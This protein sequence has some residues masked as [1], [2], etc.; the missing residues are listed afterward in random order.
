M[1]R[2]GSC[3]LIFYKV[4]RWRDEALLN[5]I[6]AWATRSV[7]SHV[8]LAIGE[9]CGSS[10]QMRNV[11]RVFNDNVRAIA[12]PH[13]PSFSTPRTPPHLPPPEP[14]SLRR[15]ASSSR[16][17][18]ARTRTSHT[19]TSAARVQPNERCS[20]LQSNSRA[21][22][23]RCQQWLAQLYG[24]GARGAITISVQV[25]YAHAHTQPAQTSTSDAHIPRPVVPMLAELVAA[26]LQAGGL[27]AVES[28]PGGATPESLHRMYSKSASCAGNP[29]IL[30]R[31]GADRNTRCDTSTASK[32]QYAPTTLR[33]HAPSSTLGYVAGAR[34]FRPT[35]VGGACAITIPSQSHHGTDSIEMGAVPSSRQPLNGLFRM[36]VGSMDAAITHATSRAGARAEECT[37]YSFRQR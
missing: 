26:T 29:Y 2:G 28:N 23:S 16:S 3:T 6:A 34:A 36:P 19:C 5:I 13:L 33:S 32:A 25:R 8:E 11:V 7:F 27:M 1:E 10:G 12:H 18:R 35:A 30:R 37:L 24:R 22:R 21:N 20:S 4:E 9:E 31:I 14:P 17:A 15:W